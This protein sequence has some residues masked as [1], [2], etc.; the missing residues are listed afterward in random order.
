MAP[1]T[2]CTVTGRVHAGVLHP[3]EAQAAVRGLRLR[4]LNAPGKAKRGR[5][6]VVA[7][8]V[9][10]KQ[11]EIIGLDGPLPK[12]LEHVLAD[13]EAESARQRAATKAAETERARVAAE[14]L[15]VQQHAELVAAMA[16]LQGD[17]QGNIAGDALTQALAGKINFAPTHEQLEAAW[18]AHVGAK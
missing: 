15:A 1:P 9:Q 3:T 12:E 14:A 18:A 8:P 7:G 13:P 11:G 5:Y 16:G 4:Q 17:A 10:F 2:L 6:E